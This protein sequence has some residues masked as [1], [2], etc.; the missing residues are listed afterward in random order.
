MGR[1]SPSSF[2]RRTACTN[3][4]SVFQSKSINIDSTRRPCWCRMYSGRTR[5]FLIIFSTLNVT[6]C[7]LP[8]GSNKTQ[9]QQRR[10]QLLFLQKKSKR[11]EGNCL[12]HHHHNNNNNCHLRRM[13]LWI[14]RAKI[15]LTTTTTTTEVLLRQ[16][17]HKQLHRRTCTLLGLSNNFK[18]RFFKPFSTTI[19]IIIII[20]TTTVTAAMQRYHR[21]H[22]RHHHHHL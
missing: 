2:R 16:S 15:Y 1:N 13:W 20:A 7:C 11:F 17:F 3:R 6:F 22:R 9:Q 18:M 8:L 14:L 4:V 5:Q 19:T 21:H 10:H 12:C